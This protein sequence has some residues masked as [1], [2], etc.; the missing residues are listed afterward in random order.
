[1]TTPRYGLPPTGTVTPDNAAGKL[2]EQLAT[3]ARMSEIGVGFEAGPV[4]P[5]RGEK[6]GPTELEGTDELDIRPQGL[7][8]WPAGK[9][10]GRLEHALSDLPENI[11]AITKHLPDVD[12]WS[13]QV[14][15]P[16]GIAVTVNFKSGRTS[17]VGSA[18][19]PA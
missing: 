1:M 16:W 12:S 18:E 14:G 13:L 17:Q 7:L 19:L 4:E 10:P 3:V 6:A 11:G 2:A 9:L 8:E 5:A 15:F